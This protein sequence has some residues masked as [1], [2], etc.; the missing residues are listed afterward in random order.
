MNKIN[1]EKGVSNW[2]LVVKKVKNDSEI[3]KNGFD[4]TKQQFGTV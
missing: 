2:L 3:V 1:I 4:L